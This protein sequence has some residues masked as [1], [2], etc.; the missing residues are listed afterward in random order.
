[1]GRA[2][3]RISA[4]AISWDPALAICAFFAAWFALYLPAYIEFATGPW[5]RD[6]NAHAPFIMAI[7]AAVAWS[8]L[9][10]PDFRHAARGGAYFAGILLAVAG[11][12]VYHFGRV[13]EATFLVSASQGV[14]AAGVA[15]ALFGFAGLRRLWFPLALTFYLVIWPAWALDALTAPLKRVV[16]EVVSTALFA[17]GLPVAHAGAVISA[18]PYQLLVAD[19]CAGLNSLI[20]LTAVGVVYLYAIRRRT[21][22]ANA[23][24]LLALAPIAI[25][26]NVARVA[27]LVLITY[28]FGYDAGQS[29]LHETAGL[30]MFAVALGAVFLTDGLAAFL[31]ERRR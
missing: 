11:L 8:K 24:V 17:A 21:I 31:W 16:S 29:F 15:L 12:G 19:A 30:A 27:A 1:M 5:R 14:L 3:S 2:L 25:G 18:G 28:H 23:A 13:G 7:A 10:S 20:A 4:P 26:A 6:E 22:L 9:T